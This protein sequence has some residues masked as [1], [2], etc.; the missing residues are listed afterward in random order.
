MPHIRLTPLFKNAT[1]DLFQEQLAT[2]DFNAIIELGDVDDACVQFSSE[3]LRVAKQHIQNRMV[4]VR[5]SDKAWFSRELRKLLRQKNRAHHA[6]K[7]TN[8]PDDWA[9]FREIRNQYYREIN[10]CKK[11]FEKQK[12]E[13]LIGMK[14]VNDKKWWHV[15]K[16]ILGQTSDCQLPPMSDDSQIIVDD[17]EK[18]DAFN[19]FFAEASYLDDTNHNLPELDNNGVNELNHILISETDVMDQLLALDTSKAYGPDSIPPKLLKESRNVICSPLTK[20]FNKSLITSK[21]PAIWKKA[22]VLP[23]FKKGA[24]NIL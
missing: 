23:I 11:T 9:R 17:K 21:F 3:I 16:D 15:L 14:G 6:A 10:Q 20:L 1:F 12:Y 22:N 8:N 4:T 7:R 19:N 13:G 18:A 5:P 2:I 24:K